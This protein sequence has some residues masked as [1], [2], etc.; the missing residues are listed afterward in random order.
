MDTPKQRRF[1]N[2]LKTLSSSISEDKLKASY[3]IMFVSGMPRPISDL[4]E[5]LKNLAQLCAN[6]MKQGVDA[7]ESGAELTITGTEKKKSQ[8]KSYL[9]E[10]VNKSIEAEK[11]LRHLYLTFAGK[12]SQLIGDLV[13]PQKRLEK[14]PD[15]SFAD[16]Y[17]D[18]I[19][20][21]ELKNK[22]VGVKDALIKAKEAKDVK[23]FISVLN[24]K[25][26][27]SNLEAMATRLDEIGDEFKK[28]YENY[29]KKIKQADQQ[30]KKKQE[31][32]EKQ[33]KER[34]AKEKQ[35]KEG[36]K[37][38]ESARTGAD[39]RLEE[40]KEEIDSIDQTLYTIFNDKGPL[41]LSKLLS[42]FEKLKKLFEDLENDESNSCLE[43][44]VKY[45]TNAVE[46]LKKLSADFP[47]E[48]YNL[49]NNANLFKKRIKKNFGIKSFSNAYMPSFDFRTL[50]G[51]LNTLKSALIEAK[52]AKPCIEVL[53]SKS[54]KDNLEIMANRLGEIGD[55]FEK[56]YNNYIDKIYNL[57]YCI[58]VETT[59]AMLDLDLLLSLCTAK[60]EALENKFRNLKSFKEY[61]EFRN[62]KYIWKGV[63]E[64]LKKYPLSNFKN[65]TSDFIKGTFKK[66]LSDLE[67][68]MRNDFFVEISNLK[69]KYGVGISSLKEQGKSVI[70]QPI[71][72]YRVF[73]ELIKNKGLLSDEVEDF[74]NKSR[75]IAEFVKSKIDSCSKED[76]ARIEK[77][78]KE[79]NSLEALEDGLR[80][81][82]SLGYK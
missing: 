43:K 59:N 62:G 77:L 73:D 46:Y 56:A 64:T 42:F 30:A 36:Q 6:S 5:F 50:K 63:D 19:D 60:N 70:K 37:K 68:K 2:S 33:E 20:W 38:I 31:E 15:C 34:Q 27:R 25:S 4:K 3:G 17:K 13:D 82:E 39:K 49:I 53:N 12:G 41:V 32:K 69:E 66:Y 54:I 35:E 16:T 47:C 40:L 79:S 75:E 61:F 7:N 74:S 24:S 28:E 81:I 18:K 65:W 58:Y 52:D 1:A 45:F 23:S 8:S 57:D 22:L 9:K 26:V 44:N 21:E 72:L 14:Y 67:T 11:Y 80:K 71:Q 10:I 55:G 48:D 29:L 78:I 76:K 51:S